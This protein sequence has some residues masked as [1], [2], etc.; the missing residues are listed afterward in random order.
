MENITTCSLKQHSEKKAIS[1]CQQ[2]DIYMCNICEKTHSE[3]CQKHIPYNLN[4]DKQIIF[5][6]RCQIKNHSDKLDYFCR[7]HN[8]LCCAACITKIKGRGNGQHID[9]NICYIEDTKIE[10]KNEFQNFIRG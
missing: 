6:G 5:T 8:E 3:L 4:I 2:C 9:C 10:K 1:Y 7:D